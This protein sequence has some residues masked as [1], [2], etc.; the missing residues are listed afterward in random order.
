MKYE[1]KPIPKAIPVFRIDIS[2]PSSQAVMEK[3][4]LFFD[5]VPRVI[6][7]KDKRFYSYDSGYDRLDL[8]LH[9]INRIIN[10][11]VDLK[12]EDDVMNFLGL[13]LVDGK[14]PDFWEPD[15]STT[16]LSQLG[17]G[18]IPSINDHWHSHTH[19]TRV[20][21]FVYDSEEYKEE[22]NNLR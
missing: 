12:T 1:V 22:L 18:K 9:H 20:I 15:Y 16:F 17:E 19:R 10:P 3:E 11:V 7:Y 14:L 5:A 8:F 21:L 2:K 6:I 13:N 4:E